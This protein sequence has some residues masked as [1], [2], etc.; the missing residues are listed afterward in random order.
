MKIVV[1]TNIVFSSLLNSNSAI[2]KILITAPQKFR[3][4]SPS[5]LKVELFRH[6]KKLLKLTKLSPK[7]LSELES[8]ILSKIFF[9]DESLIPESIF[10]SSEKLLQ[11]I[12]IWDTPFLALTIFLEGVLWSGDLKLIEGLKHKGFS[13][14]V[15]TS[16]L[17]ELAQNTK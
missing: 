16:E 10:I 13:D 12:D 6:H 2:S 3:F 15:T 14:V 4:Y 11:D 9:I 8:L 1:D 17:N 5:F 7:E